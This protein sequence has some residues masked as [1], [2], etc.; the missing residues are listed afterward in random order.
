MQPA[1]QT[2]QATLGVDDQTNFTA[3]AAAGGST[4]GGAG[5]IG[6][7]VCFLR[8]LDDH[9]ADVDGDDGFLALIFEVS[10]KRLDSHGGV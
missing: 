2:I 6:G 1:V 9:L 7:A 10:L 8:H 4:P 5:G 3:D